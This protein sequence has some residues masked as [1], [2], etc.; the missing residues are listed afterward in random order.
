MPPAR[1]PRRRATAPQVAED[2][3][4]IL[5]SDGLWDG[6]PYQ[7]AVDIVLA[8][9]KEHAGSVDGVAESLADLS[10]SRNTQDNVTCVVVGITI[11]T[12]TSV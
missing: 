3:C 4:L 1:R 7:E 11:D 2:E 10:I 8:W 9:R 5:G 12:T 6:V